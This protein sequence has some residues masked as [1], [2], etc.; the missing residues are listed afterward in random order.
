MGT[1]QTG[2]NP[3]HACPTPQFVTTLAGSW[4]INSTDGGYVEFGP[5]DVLYQDDCKCLSVAGKTPVHYSGALGGPCNQLVMSV[6]TAPIVYNG[7]EEDDMCDWVKA[8]SRSEVT[9]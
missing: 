9:V 3:W 4:F 1:Q 5:G 2:A 6:D 7:D 8:F